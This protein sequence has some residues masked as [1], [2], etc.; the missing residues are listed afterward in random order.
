VEANS[1]QNNRTF[2]PPQSSINMLNKKK[3]VNQKSQR[4]ILLKITTPRSFISSFLILNCV[5]SIG[6]VSICDGVESQNRLSPI[7]N[8][9]AKSLKR[10]QC[11]RN[12]VN[13][14]DIG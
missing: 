12:Q 5:Y 11:S 13:Y 4:K 14:K 3:D 8:M 7:E 2:L 6:K 9:V 10:A 1:K